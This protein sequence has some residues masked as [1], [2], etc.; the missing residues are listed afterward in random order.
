MRNNGPI[1]LI[2]AD[3][4]TVQGGCVPTILGDVVLLAT[5]LECT[6]LLK[7]GGKGLAH[8]SDHEEV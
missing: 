7:A 1:P 4:A 6:V 2:I 5:N 3:G 8:I